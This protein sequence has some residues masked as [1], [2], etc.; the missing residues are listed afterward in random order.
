MEHPNAL[1]VA[2]PECPGDVLAMADFIGSTSAMINYCVDS[3]ARRIH[4][5]DG[6]R[7]ESFADEARAG[8]E[9][10]LRAERELQLQRVSVHEAEH[11]REA[12]RLSCA[13]CSLASRSL[14]DIL[15]RAALP[16]ERMLAVK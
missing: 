7:R 4:R 6:E 1:V 11:A 8:Q 2:H 3:P 12:A 10:L 13:I 14:P 5:D 15:R 16:I 9:V